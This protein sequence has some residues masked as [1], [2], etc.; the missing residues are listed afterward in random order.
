MN[1]LL[2]KEA[3]TTYLA[4]L[5]LSITACFQVATGVIE[6]LIKGSDVPL[7]FIAEILKV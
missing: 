4:S 2:F 7:L 3:E 5:A 6:S 1:G